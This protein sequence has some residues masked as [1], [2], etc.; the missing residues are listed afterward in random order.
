M[1]D[2]ISKRIVAEPESPV[3]SPQRRVNSGEGKGR[4][5]LVAGLIG[6]TLLAFIIWGVLVFRSRSTAPSTSAQS[7]S[8][9]GKPALAAGTPR[10][11]RI[12]GTVEALDYRSVSAPRLSGPG[13]NQ[14]I[15]TR[16]LATGAKVKQG[17]I[18][19]EFDR[20]NQ[21]KNAL[22]RQADFRDLEEQIKKKRADNLA[23]EARD[24]TDLKAAENA[25]ETASLE[26]KRNEIISRI[27]A[28]KNAQNLEEAR[29][30]LAQL[31]ETLD[32]K[33][34]A[35]A[36]D[37]RILEI[38]RDRA[39]N[40]M[41]YARHNMERLSI[42]APIEGMVVL[43]P[44]WMQNSM[45]EVQEGDEVRAGNTFMQVVN[46][47]GMQV[48]AKVN[49]ADI[50]SL[51]VGQEVKVRLDAYPDLVLPGKLTHLAAIGV[52]SM[53]NQKIRSFT[54]VFSITGSDPRLLPDLSA[55]VE[56]VPRGGAPGR[57]EKA[58]SNEKDSKPRLSAEKR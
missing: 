32:L 45:R 22:D 14:M 17:D 16:L 46:P 27:D 15:I 2:L 8:S 55:A 51:E 58:Q 24:V 20:Q 10:P 52:T 47:A 1:A 11:L 50:G 25:V 35:R 49:Q 57:T 19:V 42:R 37:L 9:T 43:Q 6:A 56:L 21:E 41:N 3:S 28:E 39:R 5:P 53:L 7:P 44:I 29:A 31:K 23:A 4:G 30:N 26:M 13:G 36:A 33:R 34:V 18:V 40:A 54:A 38:Q 48:R 12:H